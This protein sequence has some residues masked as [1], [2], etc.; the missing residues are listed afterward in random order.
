MSADYFFPF[1]LLFVASGLFLWL[2][3]AAAFYRSL[4]MES[5]FRA[6][7]LGFA[8][9]VG[10]LQITH[11]LYP[12]HKQFAIAIVSGT[13]F[14]AVCVLLFGGI[15]AGWTR[16]RAV[17]VIAST[18]LLL[19]I[20]FITF[21]PVFNGCTKSMCHIDLGVYYLKLIRWTQS[22][23]IVPGLVNVQ[24]QLA[25]NQ[26]AFLIT[27]LFDS[28]VPNRWGMFLIAGFLPWLGLSLSAFAIVR[29]L[30]LR[31]LK[32]DSAQPIEVAYAISLPAW[33]STLATFSISSASPDCIISC[34]SIHLFL[35]FACYIASRDERERGLGEVFLV[36][37]SM[38]FREIK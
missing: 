4:G 32:R 13:A 27:S 37:G 35:V 1:F 28:L 19:G 26:S 10:L 23:P 29:L 2:L 7:W 36:G 25:F 24:E 8:L 14:V 38:P 18:A 6:P 31:L 15:L 17:A 30:I 20:S 16:K 33:I 12:I 22:F 3:G 5:I 11:F 34:L 21:V 9:L